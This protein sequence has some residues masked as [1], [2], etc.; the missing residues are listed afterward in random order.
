MNATTKTPVRKT[1]RELKRL[2]TGVRP[3]ARELN[4]CC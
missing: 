3:K 4:C 2:R 1:V